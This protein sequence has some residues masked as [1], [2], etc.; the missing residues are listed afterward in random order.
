MCTAISVFCGEHYFGRNFDYDF[1]FGE[2]VCITPRN[3]EFSFSNGEI[4]KSHSAIIGVAF[5]QNNYPLY[6]DAVNEKGLAMAGLNFPHF[7]HYFNDNN[8][9][10][11][12]A[13]YEIIPWVLCRCSN[14]KEVKELTE[15]I[16][17]T[18]RSFSESLPPSTMHW[19]VSDKDES[20][21]IEQTK[22]GIRV[23]ENP[24]GVLTNSPSFDMQLFNLNNYMSLTNKKPENRFSS[25]I[26]LETY[27]LGMGAIGLPGDNSSMSRFVRATFVKFNTIFDGSEN[28]RVRQFF[29]TLYSVYQQSGCSMADD[30]FEITNYTSCINTDKGIYYFTTYDNPQIKAVNMYNE[31]LD[32]NELIAYD[33]YSDIKIDLLN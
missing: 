17:I 21:V 18:N 2:K 29:H 13:S 22:N 19:I 31:N 6:F 20:I 33:L 27:C 1:T 32:T 11:N 8:V 7:A 28:D 25:K 12:I 4:Y 15:K 26:N 16:N 9:K 24:V 10:I 14:V 3:Y 23:Y 5:V 30:K